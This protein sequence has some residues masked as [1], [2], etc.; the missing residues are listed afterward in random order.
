MVDKK[1]IAEKLKEQA[2]EGKI[3]CHEALLLAGEFKVEP[4]I[5]GELC[6]EL[7]IKICACELGCF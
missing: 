1:L 7:K 4:G 2:P 6:N 3:S 5:I